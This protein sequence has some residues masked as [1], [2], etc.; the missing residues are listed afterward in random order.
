MAHYTE[1]DK[2]N[3]VLRVI[4]IANADCIKD[5]V[6]SEYPSLVSSVAD[7][8]GKTTTKDEVAIE[9]EDEEKG[10]AF[11]EKLLGG[12]WI[13]TSYNGNIRK[14]FAGVGY[15]YDEKLDAFIS[16]QPYPSWALDEDT[17]W[18]P[19]VPYPDDEKY[20][21]WDEKDQKWITKDVLSAE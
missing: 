17:N 9:W 1:L 13:R 11:C 14:R 4:V 2:D 18:Q 6:R 12:K 19:P 7:I 3:K 10:I 16:P 15:T 20:Y 21:T 8:S 5:S